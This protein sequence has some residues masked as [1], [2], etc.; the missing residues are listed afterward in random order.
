VENGGD[1][2]GEEVEV[3]VEAQSQGADGAK[4]LKKKK[5]KKKSKLPPAVSLD[6]LRVC[7]LFPGVNSLSPC[8]SAYAGVGSLSP[9]FSL[10]L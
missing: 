2:S 8:P 5:K 7:R 3:K 1:G 9:S 4:A 10:A 6:G